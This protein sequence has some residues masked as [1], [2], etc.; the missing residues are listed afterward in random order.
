MG[1][2]LTA[3][4]ILIGL[5]VAGIAVILLI[6]KAF[7]VLH[8]ALTSSRLPKLTSNR[9]P[10][11]GNCPTPPSRT[12]DGGHYVR[13]TR[14]EGRE[15]GESDMA[16][17]RRTLISLGEDP[18]A[19]LAE[20]RRTPG[21]RPVTKRPLNQSASPDD[22]RRRDDDYRHWLQAQQS[23][24]GAYRPNPGGLQDR[25]EGHNKYCRRDEHEPG[26]FLDRALG[27][28]DDRCIDQ[29]GSITDR[30]R[31]PAAPPA[32]PDIWDRRG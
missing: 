23:A 32:L 24:P 14:S 22:M 19:I 31:G 4:G 11:I 13:S 5:A 25:I 2:F 26:G 6:A 28:S 18:D 30:A 7:S 16:W 9:Q 27:H 8:D 12:P 29:S 20:A 17:L 15:P 10:V 3:I 21:A 1:G